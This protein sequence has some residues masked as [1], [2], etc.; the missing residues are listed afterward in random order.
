MNGPADHL[1]KAFADAAD[2]WKIDGEGG[3]KGLYLHSPSGRLF[4]WDQPKGVLYEFDSSTGNCDPIWNAANAA[5]NAE[6]WTLLPLPP[7][8]PAAAGV[9]NTAEELPSIQVAIPEGATPGQVLQVRTPEGTE[10]QFV[11]PPDAVPGQLMQVT[12]TP[13]EDFLLLH[14]LEIKVEE[15]VATVVRNVTYFA[16]KYGLS[17]QHLVELKKLPLEGQSYVDR[18][19]ANQ[20]LSMAEYLAKIAQEKPWEQE[21]RVLR[22]D[23][24]GAIL[25]S[26]LP[27]FVNIP[28]IA[29]A[30]CQIAAQKDKNARIRWYVRDLESTTGTL[31]D[32]R[33][34]T[35]K[36]PGCILRTNCVLDLGTQVEMVVEVHEVDATGAST[37]A[38]NL[39]MNSF[40][41]TVAFQETL[42]ELQARKR[43]RDDYNDRAEQRRVRIDNGRQKG[44]AVDR[45]LEQQI[46]NR[47]KLI[48]AEEEKLNLEENLTAKKHQEEA[49]MGEDGSFLGASTESGSRGGIGFVSEAADFQ[50]PKG[51]SRKDASKYKTQK[52]FEKLRK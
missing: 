4:S 17:A 8:D 39:D 11:V 10:V 43:R 23:A 28:G 44:A 29:R 38:G 31:L 48:Q 33:S 3:L 50:A 41:R 13:P 34:V 22:V 46:K 25:G 12:Y 21:Y 15:D 52:R 2:R 40:R 14:I 5:E 27:E 36:E 49:G 9:T 24:T 45:L 37:T 16:S 47:E 7:T 32:G 19:Y 35:I 26:C 6:I 42:Q 20:K 30:H 18:N 51:Y 1:R